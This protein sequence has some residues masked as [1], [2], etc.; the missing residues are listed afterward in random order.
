MP[1]NV[2]DNVLRELF[3]AGLSK[4][5]F[6]DKYQDL[7]KNPENNQSGIFS[8]N[9]N[10]ATLNAMFDTIHI[11]TGEE[12][13]DEVLNEA[14][15]KKLSGLDGDETSI[16][17]DDL[18]KLCEQMENKIKNSTMS[19][20]D[21][22]SDNN[23]MTP[24]EGMDILSALKNFKIKAAETKK[25]KLKAELDELIQNDNNISQ[26][27]KNKITELRKTQDDLEQEIKTK[28]AEMDNAQNESRR[29]K[30][31]I[32]RKQG[33]LEGTKDEDKK[34]QIQ[35]EIENLNTSLTTSNN[36]YS[37]LSKE[38]QKLNTSLSRTNKSITQIIAKLD[39]TNSTNSQKIK[40]KQEELENVDTELADDL[41]DI[42][43]QIETAHQQL[44]QALPEIGAKTSYYSD[45]ASGVVN[46]GHVGKNS[47]QALAN[48]TSQI[49][50][51]EA[52]GHN[53]GAE[54]AK[55]RNG[56]NNNAAWCASFVSW[57]YKGN[58]VFGYQASV[59]GIQESARRQGLYSEKGSYVP[60]P[61]DIMIQ[62]NGASH[63]GIVESVDPDGTIHTIEGNSSN[64]VR[65]RTYKPG[66]NGYNKISGWVRMSDTQ[67]A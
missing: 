11:K 62:K 64:A 12:K 26:Q 9:L 20:N 53:D 14:D 55:Y 25:A 10:D 38:V 31:N 37:S 13:E 34:A 3:T 51:R 27:T 8:A 52:T 41:L 57:C 46:D 1:N 60:K 7:A 19:F 22:G 59:S 45:V 48:A 35:A 30:E 32:A 36:K 17:E 16:S 56:V 58:N 33:E 24:S 63:T 40:E 28:K 61:G 2:S 47:A 43:N 29:I 44:V 67:Q 54:I 39:K 5:E 18:T 66:S 21:D 15:I 4:K 42:D 6:V 23:S 49:G 65:R 50:V